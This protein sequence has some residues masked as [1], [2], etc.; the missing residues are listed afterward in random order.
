MRYLQKFPEYDEFEAFAMQGFEPTIEL[1]PPLQIKLPIYFGNVISDLIVTLENVLMRLL[2]YGQAEI[3]VSVLDRYGSLFRYHQSPLSFVANFF[4]YYHASPTLTN[5][6]VRK[7]ILRLIGKSE[8]Y[9]H[10][11]RES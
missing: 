9:R 6:S 11:R 10:E 1:Q 7:R 3:L 8:G 5:P 2:E 4:L